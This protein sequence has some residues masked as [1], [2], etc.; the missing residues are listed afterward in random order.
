MRR[1]RTIFSTLL[2]TMP[3]VML[4]IFQSHRAKL[5]SEAAAVAADLPAAVPIVGAIEAL[6]HPQ[7]LAVDELSPQASTGTLAA[8]SAQGA[9]SRVVTFSYDATH[10]LTGQ[11]TANGEIAYEYD[12]AG[13]LIG[14]QREVHYFLPRLSR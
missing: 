7:A 1:F 11:G 2:L 12:E 3:L 4:V 10:R 5:P 6:P 8:T 13:N 9:T 14:Q